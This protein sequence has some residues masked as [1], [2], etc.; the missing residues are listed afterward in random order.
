MES[1]LL[2]GLTEAS[3]TEFNALHHAFT[4]T[5]QLLTARA[6]TAGRPI[7]SL[8]AVCRRTPCQRKHLHNSRRKACNK[9][10]DRQ[11]KPQGRAFVAKQLGRAEANPPHRRAI[12]ANAETNLGTLATRIA[13]HKPDRGTVVFEMPAFWRLSL[14]PRF[15]NRRKAR[16][17]VMRKGTDSVKVL[18]AHKFVQLQGY[19]LCQGYG[20]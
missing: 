11:L 17:S 2:K 6:R 16:D 5:V 13:K 15:E 7:D 14:A 1:L 4:R 10:C 19:S 12:V 8:K 20:V 18:D 9:G 3:L